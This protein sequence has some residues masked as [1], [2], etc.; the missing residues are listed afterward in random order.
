[1]R[2]FKKIQSSAKRCYSDVM[3]Q[4][5]V[6]KL[7]FCG[8]EFTSAFKFTK[9]ELFKLAPT[10]VTVQ[11]ARKD[12]LTEIVDAD[13]VVPFMCTIHQK[14][15]ES[16]T[17]LKMIMQFGVGLEGVNTEAATKA[18]IWV[19]KIP[20]EGTGNAE[21]C[22]EH[23]IFLS[24]S[25]LRNVTEMQRSLS[26]GNLGQPTGKT[27]F[28]STAIVY[29]YGG[30]GKQLVDRLIG[31]QMVVVVVVRSI[32]KLSASSVSTLQA[33]AAV[34]GSSVT[35]ITTRA[36]FE[37][38]LTKQASLLY[39]CCNQSAENMGMVN[40]SFLQSLSRGVFVIN[41]ARVS[42]N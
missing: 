24:L 29:G 36:F 17:K 19:C 27:L 32:E 9:E 3:K 42:V 2:R 4:H 16:A 20:S 10:G 5:H 41:V 37:H 40:A 34:C 22:A 14:E 15:L 30:I 1:M 6:F 23:A 7:L 26:S 11:C 38:P 31:F 12:V 35:F 39:L 18:G 28:K 21:S 13:V 33:A 25:L 8:N